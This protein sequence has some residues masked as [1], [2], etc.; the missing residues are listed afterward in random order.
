MSSTVPTIATQEMPRTTR[1][2]L[3]DH[4]RVLR[5]AWEQLRDNMQAANSE[6][7]RLSR[8]IRQRTMEAMESTSS[9]TLTEVRRIL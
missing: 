7:R 5:R 3:S 2:S 9:I 8:E 1:T 4:E 6:N